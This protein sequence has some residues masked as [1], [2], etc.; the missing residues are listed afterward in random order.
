MTSEVDKDG[1]F[2]LDRHALVTLRM[3]GVTG[4]RMEGGA[5]SVISELIVR[6]LDADTPSPTGRPALGR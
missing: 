4:L 5:G 1:Y 2:V 3:T 6:R